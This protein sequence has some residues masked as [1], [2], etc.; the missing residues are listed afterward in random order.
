M[1]EATRRLQALCH[2][3]KC[4]SLG[5]VFDTPDGTVLLVVS[6]TEPKLVVGGQ[7]MRLKRGDR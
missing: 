6:D 3:L 7:V 5:A 2:E 4:D 1:T